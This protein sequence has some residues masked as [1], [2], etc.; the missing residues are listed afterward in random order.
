MRRR[1]LH[2]QVETNQHV[3]HLLEVVELSTFRKGIQERW[4]NALKRRWLIETGREG[5]HL[6][7]GELHDDFACE[8]EGTEN[9][10]C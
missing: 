2:K 6:E 3:G 5:T 4:G 9:D 7:V 8:I 1:L 10:L